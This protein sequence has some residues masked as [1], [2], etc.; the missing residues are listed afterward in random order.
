[1]YTH[2]VQSHQYVATL[3]NNATVGGNGNVVDTQGKPG[4]TLLEVVNNGTGTATIALYGTFLTTNSGGNTISYLV[5]YQPYGV[6]SPTPTV[7]TISI[8]ANS[9]AVFQVLDTGY[10]NYFATLSG[11]TGFVNVTAKLISHP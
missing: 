3:Q 5:R 9:S 10:I 2:K 4:L 6:A 8:A 11:I 7:A 1:M